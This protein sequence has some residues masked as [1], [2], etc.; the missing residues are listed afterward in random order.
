MPKIQIK[1]LKPQ[2]WQ[3][4]AVNGAVGAVSTKNLVQLD[5]YLERADVAVDHEIEIDDNGIGRLESQPVAAMLR[6]IKGSYI[7]TPRVARDIGKWLVNK[8]D[9]AEKMVAQEEIDLQKL[10]LNQKGQPPN[11][12]KK[13]K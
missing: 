5:F 3:T 1:Y 8:A 6:E 2:E 4:Q 9:E 11:K 12:A 10:N 7:M 13:Q